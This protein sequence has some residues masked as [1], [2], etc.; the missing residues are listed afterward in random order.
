M[1][2]K[3]LLVE[4]EQILS[5]LLTEFL[6]AEGYEVICASNGEEGLDRFLDRQPDICLFDVTMPRMNGI[7]L[8]EK[9]RRFDFNTPIMI[10][11]A[12][13]LKEDVIKALK[14][15]AD[16]YVTKPFNFQ[17]LNLRLKNIL[18]RSNKGCSL[19][20][21]RIGMFMFDVN[22]QILQY[23]SE[24]LALTAME[25]SLLSMFC[26]NK[27]KTL[28]RTEIFKEYWNTAG[29]NSRSIDVI[30]SKLRKYLGRDGSIRII[31]VRGIGYRLVA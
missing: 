29:L 21:Y 7:K 6:E 3:L 15:G 26:A 17:E 23:Q 11:T 27:N 12:R 24:S 30:V 31:S 10:L 13:S 1:K 28:T 19:G 4:D 2:T 25:T 8:L 5:E 18:R 14:T 16:D 9:V 20:N 22:T